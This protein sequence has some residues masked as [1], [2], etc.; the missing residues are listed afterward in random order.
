MAASARWWQAGLLGGRVWL[1][2]R[3][4]FCRFC[5][6]FVIPQSGVRQEEH[7]SNLCHAAATALF[8]NARARVC[9]QESTATTSAHIQHPH[10]HPLEP[11]PPPAATATAPA[12]PA[13]AAVSAGAAMAAAVAAADARQRV[14]FVKGASGAVWRGAHTQLSMADPR[15]TSAT[16]RR[17]LQRRHGR[18]RRAGLPAAAAAQPGHGR[19]A[20][21]PADGRGA[22]RAQPRQAGGQL[23]ARRRQHVRVGCGMPAAAP[24]LR[25]ACS[26]HVPLPPAQRAGCSVTASAAR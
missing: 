15:S 13:A 4:C 10:H 19:A 1:P 8:L 6:W 18:R 26:M 14:L 23:L 21:V 3:F 16:R 11:A 25:G 22:L 7:A 5:F 24:A 9:S 17:A 12:Q 2:V 20:A